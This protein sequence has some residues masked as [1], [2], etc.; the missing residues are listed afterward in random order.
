VR[1]A[2]D[3]VPL[4]LGSS[5]ITHDDIPG[6]D[7]NVNGGS[8][9]HTYFTLQTKLNGLYFQEGAHVE[10]DS[11]LLLVP[12]H[13]AQACY[14]Y[15]T[16]NTYRLYDGWSGDSDDSYTGAW[17]QRITMA[18]TYD[19]GY[20]YVQEG[21]WIIYLGHSASYGLPPSPTY[22]TGREETTDT[23]LASSLVTDSGAYRFSPPISMD[24]FFSGVDLVEQTFYTHSSTLGAVYGHGANNLEGFPDRFPSSPPPF[25]GWA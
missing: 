12:F 2:S 6:S 22:Y 17:G 3:G 18:T 4:L 13:D 23:I 20:T 24:V 8:R 10:T 19:G 9:Y 15:G 16:R 7:G 25:T 11:H 1:I 5:S 14:V 21:D